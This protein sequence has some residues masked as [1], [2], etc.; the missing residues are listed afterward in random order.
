MQKFNLVST[1][2]VCFWLLAG[3]GA[4]KGYK[5][6]DQG[7]NAQAYLI[8]AEQ[9]MDSP[10]DAGAL[11]GQG[12][13]AFRMGFEQDGLSD[14]RTAYALD[15]GNHKI[16]LYLAEAEAKTGDSIAA[17]NL[18][19]TYTVKAKPIVQQGMRRAGQAMLIQGYADEARERMVDASMGAYPDQD[20]NLLL[21]TYY[22]DTSREPGSMTPCRK[23]ATAR[24]TETINASNGPT[25]A[26]SWE[27][28]E[29]YT[30]ILGLDDGLNMAQAS[31]MARFMGAGRYVWGELG[32]GSPVNGWFSLTDEDMAMV[33]EVA[34]DFYNEFN[35]AIQQSVDL[36][37]QFNE[38]HDKALE[39]IID[40]LRALEE[41][42][43]SLGVKQNQ[44]LARLSLEKE[45]I[46]KD[47][48]SAMEAGEDRGT[49]AQKARQALD[50]L[51]QKNMELEL[52]WKRH[53]EQ[54]KK[55]REALRDEAAR[56]RE[57]VSADN[58]EMLDKIKELREKALDMVK[59]LALMAQ[60]R[61]Q[62]RENIGAW[63]AQVVVELE[64]AAKPGELEELS[65]K[66]F[67]E[68]SVQI[69]EA[70]QLSDTLDRDNISGWLPVY[71][72]DLEAYQALPP[73]QR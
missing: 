14:L 53:K 46:K 28:L 26:V 34:P 40:K 36:Q 48:T 6:L 38:M 5:A 43:R 68:Y 24:I 47:F 55:E 23:G 19:K 9:L 67:L 58:R 20:P 31:E 37:K 18:L 72:E 30:R 32:T 66:D 21:W 15:P 11:A 65:W 8:F 2:L 44:D 52:E 17:G 42:E 60:I 50:E 69:E 64:P 29:A 61:G 45:A 22:R 62:M 3:C 10:R 70:A 63:L 25:Q 71:H 35:E 16:I 27:R 39:P 56:A 13:S 57:K 41:K 33:Q 54:I 7:D 51:E 12:I 1:M 4:V 73:C 59:Q 49:A